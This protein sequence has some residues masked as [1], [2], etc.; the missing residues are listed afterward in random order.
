MNH[1][2]M[3]ELHDLGY[4]ILKTYIHDNFW[5]QRRRKGCITIETTWTYVGDFDSQMIQIDDGE[6]RT[7]KPEHLLVFDEILNKHK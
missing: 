7:L 5:T 1:L 4:R 3:Q 6:W 2:S